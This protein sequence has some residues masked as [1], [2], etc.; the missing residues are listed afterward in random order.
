MLS[1]FLLKALYACP[2]IFG[3]GSHGFAFRERWKIRH[4]LMTPPLGFHQFPVLVWEVLSV[5]LYMHCGSHILPQVPC[6]EAPP[7]YSGEAG[8]SQIKTPLNLSLQNLYC[9]A[10]APWE[11]WSAEVAGDF[12]SMIECQSCLAL[13]RGYLMQASAFI[14]GFSI[15]RERWSGLCLNLLCWKT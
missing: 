7:A 14:S 6:R 5:A 9:G 11:R 15:T 3:A 12:I 10:A 13:E 8:I 2:G 1:W 4:C